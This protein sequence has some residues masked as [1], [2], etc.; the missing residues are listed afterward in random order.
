MCWDLRGCDERHELDRY[1]SGERYDGVKNGGVY[2]PNFCYTR[3]TLLGGPGRIN[4]STRWLI[5][6]LK[7]RSNGAGNQVNS[8]IKDCNELLA[9]LSDKNPYHLPSALKELE[10]TTHI[11]QFHF[12]TNNTSRKKDFVLDTVFTNTILPLPTPPN[13]HAEPEPVLTELP[14][15]VMLTET[16]NPALS[17]TANNQLQ[18]NITSPSQQSPTRL[19]QPEDPMRS[20]QEKEP[21]D[22][23]PLSTDMSTHIQVLQSTSPKIENPTE[24]HKGSQPSNPTGPSA[25]KA[26]FKDTSE[27]ESPQFVQEMRVF[28]VAEGLEGAVV[29]GF[30]M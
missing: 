9:E 21:A 29:K 25:R 19:G 12:D 4:L 1:R 22:L 14:K 23:P 18:L 5:P 27:I 28:W 8:L 30:M 11:F 16:P 24:T 26:L 13:E 15:P 17:R 2:A 3:Y 20:Q 6:G 10:G 7:L